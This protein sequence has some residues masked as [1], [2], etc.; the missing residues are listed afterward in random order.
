MENLAG[1]KVLVT[2]DTGFIGSWMCQVL[3]RMGAKVVGIGLRP[4]TKPSLFKV[5]SLSKRIEHHELDILQKVKLVELV[6]A[7]KPDMVIHLAAQSLVRR[8]YLEPMMTFRVNM[9]GTV[10]LLEAIKEAKI[11]STI[12]ATTDK[13]YLTKG[14]KDFNR[15]RGFR[16]TDQLGGGK[17]AYS[18]S[19]AGA[20]WLAQQYFDLPVG[21]ARASN[22]IGGG[23]W[24]KDR[25]LPDLVATVYSKGRSLVIR[26]PEAV[27][28]WQHV[29]EMVG[30]YLTLG[31][32]LYQGKKTAGVYNFGPKKDGQ[33]KVIEFINLVEELSQKKVKVRVR[34]EKEKPEEKYVGLQTS[35]AKDQLGWQASLSLRQALSLSLDWYEAYYANQD[36]V[37]LTNL[38]IDQYFGL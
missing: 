1:L 37:K 23:D 26:Y 17:D 21:I 15:D 33:V 30:G 8:S 4:Q 9:I 13:V 24:S 28:A 34:G 38:Q 7:E 20:D 14:N 22:V 18:L 31:L 6:K 16:E 25:L 2:G 36:A 19:K 32:S 11:K 27:R 3:L 35:K 29:L 5:L 12:V 10:N